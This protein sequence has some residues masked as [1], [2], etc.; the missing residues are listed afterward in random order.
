[1]VDRE[2]DAE[3]GAD[4]DG[5]VV[6]VPHEHGLV[7]LRDVDGVVPVQYTPDGELPD[8]AA[9]FREVMRLTADSSS[10]VR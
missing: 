10:E 6:L 7:A 8:Q 9:G 3:P 1:M 5:I 2:V 4:A